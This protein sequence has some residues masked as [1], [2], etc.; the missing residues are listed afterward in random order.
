[1]TALYN[2]TTFYQNSC[3]AF[4][5]IV[6]TGKM[7]C[8]RYQKL[9]TTQTHCNWL[10]VSGVIGMIHMCAYLRSASYNVDKSWAEEELQGFF[11][12]LMQS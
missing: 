8:K 11:H 1:M 5:A 7:T 10:N 3:K 2:P 12:V 4:P 6:F 9:H